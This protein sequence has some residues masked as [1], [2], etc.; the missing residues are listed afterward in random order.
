MSAQ[1]TIRPAGGTWV[2]R[3]GGAV[4]GES[5]EAIELL[6]GDYA[7]VIYFPRKDLAMA[8][9][10]PTEERSTCPRKGEAQYFDIEIKSGTIP[11]AAWSYAEP[12]EAVAQ[13]K[14]HVA[15]YTEFVTIERV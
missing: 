14:D 9:L 7:P 6:E 10:E 3:T 12:K 4:I 2:V 8:F 15:F 13:I 5:S 11:N 1:F